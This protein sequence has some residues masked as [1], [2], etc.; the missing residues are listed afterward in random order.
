MPTYHIMVHKIVGV[1]HSQRKG[2]IHF[3][4]YDPHQDIFNIVLSDPNR[5]H[6]KK[7]HTCEFDV[8]TYHFKV[9][10]IVSIASYR[11][12]FRVFYS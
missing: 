12:I 3:H 8:P 9:Q 7:L 10:K 4:Y 6:M 11:V 2:V 5:V 1:H